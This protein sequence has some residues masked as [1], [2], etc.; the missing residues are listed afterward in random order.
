MCNT[1]ETVTIGL[2]Q[3]KKKLYFVLIILHFS[4]VDRLLF[5]KNNIPCALILLLFEYKYSIVSQ[6]CCDDP[7]VFEIYLP[8]FSTVFP[9]IELKSF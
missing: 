4:V 1:L 3:T 6:C 8:I 7:N 9:I 5:I 2:V